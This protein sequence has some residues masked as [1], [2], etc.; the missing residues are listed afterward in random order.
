MSAAF[1]R[2]VDA[3]YALGILETCGHAPIRVTLESMTDERGEVQMVIL[4]IEIEGM[5]R[6][7]VLAA[8]SGG[9]GVPLQL[10]GSDSRDVDLAQSA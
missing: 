9:H 3:R 10:P 7:R 2:A 1:A 6:D 8:F 4:H 5:A